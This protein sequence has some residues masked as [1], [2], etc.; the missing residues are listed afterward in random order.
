MYILLAL[1]SAV[2]AQFLGGLG[3]GGLGYGGMGGLGYGGMGGLGYGG[4]GGLGYGGMGGLGYGGWLSGCSLSEDDLDELCCG[5]DYYPS[6]CCYELC[7]CDQC[8]MGGFFPSMGGFGSQ[9]CFSPCSGGFGFNGLGNGCGYGCGCQQP[10]GF[11]RYSSLNN[12]RIAGYGNGQCANCYGAGNTNAGYNQG[13]V[14]GTAGN[15]RLNAGSCRS[16]GDRQFANRCADEFLVRRCNDCCSSGRDC[17]GNT[18]A[19]LCAGG[20]RISG[21]RNC[22]NANC[23][24]SNAAGMN[25]NS[26]GICG[27]AGCCRS[28]ACGSGSPCGY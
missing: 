16:A 10:I 25:S 7:G 1:I 23:C 4:M 5:S 6:G 22:G 20:G 13:S 21:N 2:S 14:C 9:G 19:N 28:S 12:G 26:N 15:A 24:H 11:N 3:M 27:S 17:Y 8:G 18:Q